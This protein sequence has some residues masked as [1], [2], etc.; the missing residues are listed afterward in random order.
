[1]IET[2]RRSMHSLLVEL[3]RAEPQLLADYAR[4]RPALRGRIR[5]TIGI[6]AIAFSSAA[7]GFLFAALPPAFALLL[8]AP[9]GV[10]ALLVIWAL[11]DSHHPPT[12]WMTNCFFAFVAVAV[13]WPDYLALQLPGLPWI[14]MRRLALAP[15]C[16]LFLVALSTSSTF[17]HEMRAQLDRWPLLWKMM[18]GFIAIQCA[19]LVAA[20]EKYEAV[21]DLL[22]YQ[23]VW[24]APFF[25]GAWIFR[26]P[27]R[28]ERFLK[29]FIGLCLLIGAIG[30]VEYVNKGVLWADHIPPFLQVDLTSMS[31]T[32][33][34]EY[35]NGLYRSKSVFNQPLPFA[36]IMALA[37]PLTL[38]FA[39][40]AQGFFYRAGWLMLDLFI[41]AVLFLPQSRL[42]LIGFAIGHAVWLLLR[43][44]RLW[45]LNRTSLAGPAFTLAYPALL[46]GLAAAVMVVPAL[47]QR[48]VGGSDT[49]Y[50]DQAR[51]VQKRMAVPV[52]AKS[53]VFGYGP[54]QGAQALGY[55]GGA[56]G[57]RLTIDNY[58]LWIALDYGLVGFALYYGMILLALHRLLLSG[59]KGKAA[60]HDQ[61][62]LL[63][64]IL[65]AF[66]LIKTV[67]SE[68]DNHWLL[69]TLL[70]MSFALVSPAEAGGERA[71]HQRGP[72]GRGDSAHQ[73][74]GE[75]GIDREGRLG[76]AAEA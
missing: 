15:M 7:Y 33:S 74:A 47:R 45:L 37:A 13:A 23:T 39:G 50:S 28:I 22:N 49:V 57:S 48:V 18:L 75:A 44:G 58:L 38:Y 73:R 59:F 36:E 25:V 10:L 12:R 65:S 5:A 60:A 53:P 34:A 76:I 9:V 64:A 51:K 30:M 14:S 2:A 24:I 71:A 11:P 63:V 42:G 16:L 20:E 21:K 3:L 6:A 72:R 29:L 46:L 61:A 35:R 67:L 62:L 17:R 55:R 26:D 69:F 66:L 4:Q 8:L 54:R 52:I 32:L 31:G 56:E 70:G 27:A 1:M 41:L 68:E 19:S 40:R 43:F